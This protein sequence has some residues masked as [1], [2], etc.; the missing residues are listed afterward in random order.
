MLRSR[1][2][3]SGFARVCSGVVN[4]MLEAR[5]LLCTLPH[6]LLGPAPEWSDAIEAQANAQEGG[7]E[8]VN[9]IWANRNV[10]D[11]FSNLGA[12]ADAGRAVVDGVLAYWEKIITSWN[13]ADGTTTLQVNITMSSS[14]GFGAAG[15]PAGTAPADG[16]PR[17]G[18]I[19]LNR[20]DNTLVNNG[21]HLDPDPL[22]FEEYDG[23]IINA[24]AGNSSV[25]LGSDMFSL[26]SAELAHVMGLI[27]DFGNSGGSF[28]GYKLEN[29]VTNT[30]IRDNAEGGG[31]FGFFYTFDG[32]TIDH[33]LTS[34]NSGD[35]TSSSWGN[36][37]HTAGT[38]G[39]INFAGQNW[40]GGEDTGNARYGSER[41]LPSYVMSHILKDAYGYSIVSPE[42][43]GTMYVEHDSVTGNVLV[44]GGDFHSGS[45]VTNDEIFIST[46]GTDMI[47]TVDVPNDIPGTYALSGGGDFPGWTTRIPIGSVNTITVNADDGDDIIRVY[48]VPA[49]VNVV[50]N[51]GTGNDLIQV[52]DGDIDD[53][54][55]GVRDNVFVNGGTGTDSL[56]Y[57]DLTDNVGDDTYT[58]TSSTIIKTLSGVTT[59]GSDVERIDVTANPF[60]N[61]FDINSVSSATDLYLSGFSGDDTYNLAVDFDSTIFGFVSCIGGAGADKILIDDS[62]DILD[63]SYV[64]SGNHFDK[65]GTGIVYASSSTE[66]I[67][68]TLNPANNSVNIP[69]VSSWLTIT[70]RGGNGN[71]NFQTGFNDLDSNILGFLVAFGDAGTDS[72]FFDDS[73][74]NAGTN[75]ATITSFSVLKGSMTDAIVYGTM[76]SCTFDGSPLADAIT[77]TSA[78]NSWT[79]NGNGG[80]D[81]IDIVSATSIVTV[82]SGA[83]NDTVAVNSDGTGTANVRFPGDETL[84][85]LF[86]GTGGSVLLA[87]GGNTIDVTTS[88]TLNGDLNLNDGYFIRRANPNAAFY[89]TRLAN[90]YNGG[91]W[92][93]GTQP[94]ISSNAAGGPFTNDALGLAVFTAARSFG[95][96]AVAAG[97]LGIGYTVIG[98]TN[99]DFVV[100]FDDLLTQAQNYGLVAPRY[101]YQGNFD[102][103]T[104]VDFDDLLKLAQNY[105]GIPPL[106][107]AASAWEMVSGTSDDELVAI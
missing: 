92:V 46:D 74:A 107:R 72:M 29:F 79:I 8:A 3:R 43:F 58:I 39:N 32:P 47:I 69:Q 1:S 66:T 31:N 56:S 100:N 2:T 23:T 104:D 68:A 17:T 96:V 103:D 14:N 81:D 62:T 50:V 102:Y 53:A 97:D 95:G 38:A 98:D 78:A 64:I 51:A 87:T 24:F 34:Y 10:S 42:T 41:T 55:T 77:M 30:G 54:T 18:S 40:R 6:E 75:T 19:S 35:P 86:I 36:A 9:L 26:I 90:G 5:K 65:G 63:D 76:E 59:Y 85:T 7:P 48:G 94:S 4:E 20:G 11:G 22:D 27:S 89:H 88:V 44:R 83:G 60:N 82:V 15:G 84:S 71:D 45:P 70:V 16:K 101:W 106:L 91:L 80:A 67:D 73:N 61:T 33:L 57:Y 13:R 105:G 12:A 49:G 93:G 52:G 99:L 37:V 28:Q 25:G 21:W